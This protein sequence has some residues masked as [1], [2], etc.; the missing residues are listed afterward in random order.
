M[1]AI[2]SKK[3]KGLYC[4]EHLKLWKRFIFAVGL[5][6]MSYAGQL[7]YLKKCLAKAKR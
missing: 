1:C 2:C 4:K 7:D 5:N 6:Y 3:S